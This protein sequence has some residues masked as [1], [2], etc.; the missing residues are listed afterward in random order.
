MPA[1]DRTVAGTM[2]Q[3]L[4][5]HQVDRIFC[6]A[7]ESYLPLLDALY[8]CEIDVLG[9]R[10]EGSAGFA[11]LAD[12][13]LTGRAGVCLVSRAPG[14]ANAAIAVHAAAEDATPLVV[15]V[16]DVP[17]RDLGRESFQSGRPLDDLAKAVLTLYDPAATGETVRRAFR[18][19]E[20]ATPGPV[21]V[22]VPEDVFDRAGADRPAGRVAL[23][24]TVPDDR[25]FATVHDLL[26]AARRPLLLAGSMLDTASGRTLL[27]QI[28]ERHGLPV[29]TSNKNQHLLDNRHRCYA[30]HL[31]NSTQPEQLA[32]FDR[33]DLVLAVGTRLGQTTTRRLRFPRGPEPDQALV[34]VYPDPARIGR[35]HRVT[36][37]FAMD[38]VDFL[39]RLAG[40]GPPHRL[41]DGRDR[42]RDELH[43]IEEDNARWVPPDSDAVTVGEIASALDE[44][45]E[46]AVTVIVDSGT[47]TSWT[48]R[49]LRFAENG[50]LV[51][52]DSSAMGFAPGAAL[53]VA[54]RTR[55]VPTVAIVGDGGFVMNGGEL[56]T[57]CERRLPV[58]FVVS[59]NASLG[60]IRLHQQQRYPDR[61]I[62]T[63]LANPDFPR[64]AEA[65]GALGLSATTATE[66]RTGLAKA[67][68]HPG[69]SLLAVRT[70]RSHLTPY[71]HL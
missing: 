59:D 43:A 11:A 14:A 57:V 54:A 19:A 31:H 8:D 53:A 50:R 68:D 29:V 67:L 51:G 9:C 64:L 52:I 58:V 1:P 25:D 13:K 10:H 38:P 15:L 71:R 34:H 45:T 12:A 7:G 65:Y 21:V 6:V 17:T 48:Y 4:R 61:G 24:H 35:Y 36:A 41:P 5:A 16:G 18:V 42:W 2:V 37:G 63:D 32:E 66:V 30:G 47:F 20:S 40:A 49:F 27:R 56:A 69:P 28:A 39:A 23:G 46:G 44:L 70:S 3:S 55:A 62:G 22:H 26:T 33:A 60:T